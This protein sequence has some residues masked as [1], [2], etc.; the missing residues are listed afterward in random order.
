[1]SGL[2]KRVLNSWADLQTFLTARGFTIA[3][4]KITYDQTP[5]SSL[6]YWSY[7]SSGTINFKNSQGENAFQHNLTDFT[8]G[9]KCGC[10]FVELADNGFALYLSPVTSDFS[11]TDL[12]FCCENNYTEE[13]HV[14]P[15]E[16]IEIIDGDNPLENGLVIATP[17]DEDGY[18]HFIWRDKKAATQIIYKLDEVA[19]GEQQ[20]ESID[21]TI[22]DNYYFDVDD[23]QGNISI[24]VEIPHTKMM[25]AP[26]TVTLQ[27]AYLNFGEWSKYIYTQVL[28]QVNP[29]GNVFK[30]N[31]QKF[32]SFSD[33]A[34]WRCPVFKLPP[35][36]VT[37]NDSNSTEQYSPIKTYKIGDYCINEG[38]LWKCVVAVTTPCPFDQTNWVVTTVPYELAHS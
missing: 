5:N 24:G 35:T 27:K 15:T 3:N 34:E 25:V 21:Q 12:T 22:T 9:K 38:L 18:W 2:Y 23:T 16:H 10:I 26:L 32:I 14:L 7:D 11:V 6:C 36:D 13:D 19:E 28:G 20:T 4:N 29:P 30:I 1:M 8:N 31:G 33:T 37:P 17:T